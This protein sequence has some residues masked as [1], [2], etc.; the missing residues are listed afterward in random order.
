[1]S[2]GV[3]VMVTGVPDQI[4][5]DVYRALG[6]DF[7]RTIVMSVGDQKAPEI[8]QLSRVGVTTVASSP[9]SSWAPAWREGVERTWSTATAG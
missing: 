1:M 8:Q 6:K 3:L 5:L 2:G 9:S 4:A 7:Y